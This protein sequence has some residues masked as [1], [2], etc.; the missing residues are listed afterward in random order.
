MIGAVALTDGITW[1]EL[2]VWNAH[3]TK[4]AEKQTASLERKEISAR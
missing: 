4:M 2:P 1:T 3:Q